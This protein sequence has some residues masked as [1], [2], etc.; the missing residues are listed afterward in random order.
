MR[1]LYEAEQLQ[2]WKQVAVVSIVDY[3][4]R[5]LGHAPRSAQERMRVARALADLPALMGVRSSSSS[6]GARPAD[7]PPNDEARLHTLRFD[8]ISASAFALFRQNRCRRL[9]AAKRV[10]RDPM[11]APSRLDAAVTRTHAIAALTTSGWKRGTATTTV[12]DARAHV[13]VDAPLEVL[14]EAFRRCPTRTIQ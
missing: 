3:L 10:S 6:Q 1:W 14:R 7:L 4:E 2:T 12:D 5:G 9:D 11:P 13:G 8:E